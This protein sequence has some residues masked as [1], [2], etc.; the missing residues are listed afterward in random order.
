M[1]VS[2]NLTSM[3]QLSNQLDKSAS[4]V[5][6]VNETSQ[7]SLKNEQQNTKNDE[8][9]E[10]IKEPDLV[11]E[12]VNQIQIPIAYD[13]NAEVISTQDSTTQTLLDIKA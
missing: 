1:Q 10:P 12:M 8:K 13:A 2:N 4:E 3:M 7:N 9:K 11:K 6:R 5:A